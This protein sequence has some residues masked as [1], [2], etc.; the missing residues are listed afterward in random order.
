MLQSGSVLP[1]VAHF[2]LI[3]VSVL[4]KME[5]EF[6]RKPAGRM[7]RRKRRQY[8]EYAIRRARGATRGSMREGK[9]GETASQA[10]VAA[11]ISRS[12]RPTSIHCR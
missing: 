1:K 12:R 11:G 3:N 8:N 10:A 2:A 9:E 5:A 6:G 4:V 7:L